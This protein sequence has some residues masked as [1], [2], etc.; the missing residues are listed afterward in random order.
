MGLISLAL[1]AKEKPRGGKF[2]TITPPEFPGRRQP[3]NYHKN[4]DF[5]KVF[6]EIE[7]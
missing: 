5:M 2:A 7:D 3:D 6:C 1:R 4:N